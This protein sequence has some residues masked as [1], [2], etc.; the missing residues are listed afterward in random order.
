MN[1]SDVDKLVNECHLCEHL[2]EKFPNSE[3]VYLGK[4]NDLVLVG[5]APAN[6]GWRVSHM[7][8]RDIN[9]KML[10]SGVVLQR[11]FDII[12]A[13]ILDTTFIE[14][15]KCYPVSRSNIPKCLKNCEKIREMQIELLKPKL[16]IT[17]GDAAT[18]SLIGNTYKKFSDVVGK[19]F[20]VNGYNVLPIYHPSPVSP[21]SYK[22]NVEIFEKLRDGE[23]EIK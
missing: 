15:I 10:P 8:W 6:N 13:D 16:V 9:G 18:K 20:N 17:L 23:Y 1:L 2:V 22:G 14:A 7:L 5:E 3:T 12:G 4:N 21:M 11:L 19:L